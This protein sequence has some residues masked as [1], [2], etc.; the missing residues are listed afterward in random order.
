MSTCKASTD[1]FK[2]VVQGREW[3][4]DIREEP[5]EW[6]FAGKLGNCEIANRV[7]IPYRWRWVVGVTMMVAAAIAG[8][9]AM[10]IF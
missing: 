8:V 9:T 4:S 10:V 3:P 2:S 5:I 6:I 7:I 1:R